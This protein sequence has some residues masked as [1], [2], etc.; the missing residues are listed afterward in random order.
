[1]IEK[2]DWETART[3]FEALLVN[4]TINIETYK[5]ALEA[6]DRKIKEFP[7]EK[8]EDDP[9]PVELKQVLNEIKDA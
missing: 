5:Y 3:Q 8:K 4:A 6:I 2:R 1:M 9:M 7:V